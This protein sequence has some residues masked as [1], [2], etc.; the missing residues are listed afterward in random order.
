M[1]ILISLGNSSKSL[2]FKS[3]SI[4][5]RPGLLALLKRLRQWLAQEVLSK[6][7]RPVRQPIK[8]LMR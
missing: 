7:W 1:Q 4:Y 5:Y 6:A 8:I 3:V 2:W